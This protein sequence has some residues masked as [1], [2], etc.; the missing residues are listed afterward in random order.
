MSVGEIILLCV[1]LVNIGWAFINWRRRANIWNQRIQLLDEGVKFRQAASELLRRAKHIARSAATEQEFRVC[2]MCSQIR[3]RFIS[4]N[5][6]P[7]CIECAANLVA[8][9]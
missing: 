2:S 6:V 5:G 8:K 1:T 4:E 7:T 3:T 9:E